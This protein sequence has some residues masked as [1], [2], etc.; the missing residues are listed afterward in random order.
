MD[1]VDYD[2]RIADI[3]HLFRNKLWTLRQKSGGCKRYECKKVIDEMWNELETI[4][5]ANGTCKDTLQ[6]MG[7]HKDW[8]R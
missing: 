5:I 1:K 8:T 6:V 4:M 3:H 7:K 2:K